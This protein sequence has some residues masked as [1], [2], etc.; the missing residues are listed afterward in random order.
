MK[1]YKSVFIFLSF[2]LAACQSENNQFEI[3]TDLVKSRTEISMVD[4]FSV[5]LSTVKLDSIP[6]SAKSVALVG[7]MDDQSTGKTEA[8]TYMNFD[9][10]SGLSSIT[11]EYIFDSVCI[12]LAFAD[13]L[14]GDS[15]QL[16]NLEVYRLTE[17]MNLR[18]SDDE[19]TYL[20]NTSS[21]PYEETPCGEISY[22]P[23]TNTDSLVIRLDDAIGKEIMQ[24]SLDDADEVANTDNFNSYL[25]GFIIKPTSNSGEAIVGFVADSVN[26][27]LYT[28]QAELKTVYTELKATVSSD[29]THFN[30]IITDRS[31]T[32]FEDLS[33]QQEELPSSATNNLSY[34][35]GSAGVMT[36]IDFPTLNELFTLEDRILLRV[37][38]IL[39]PA[40]E[41]FDFELPETLNFYETDKI[42][43]LG[44]QLTYESSSTTYSVAASLAYDELYHE[45]SYYSV[46][47]TSFFSEELSGNYYDTS[48][49][50][51]ITVPL[52]DFLTKADHLIL[53]GENKSGYKPSL[54]LYFLTYE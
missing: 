37:E 29:D 50:L 47:L 11:E 53:K 21:F 15:T 32:Y 34:I 49:G 31:G 41:S 43:Q 19:E 51:L 36:R 44:D 6:T 45:N 1:K 30:Q 14:I 17:R 8:N 20:F 5:K 4:S 38:L 26:L 40:D 46:D 7:L 22:Y 2:L 12:R 35:Q 33:T 39:R 54:N 18:E 24:L 27:V 28:H 42:N 23:I 9:L 3:G 16:Q 25:K 10:P 13:Y 52:T 48:H